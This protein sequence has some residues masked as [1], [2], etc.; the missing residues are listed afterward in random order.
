MPSLNIA[1]SYKR[2][3][4]ANFW[5]CTV[6]VIVIAV[7]KAS[8]VNNGSELAYLKSSLYFNFDGQGCWYCH[9]CYNKA[10]AVL[11][12][13]PSTSFYHSLI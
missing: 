9:F 11:L 4:L 6:T 2:E 13:V 12:L 1:L 8:R 5:L 3:K 10:L 7:G